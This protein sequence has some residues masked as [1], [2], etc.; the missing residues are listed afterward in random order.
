MAKMASSHDLLSKAFHAIN[1][2]KMDVE[3]HL[4]FGTKKQHPVYGVHLDATNIDLDKL[5]KLNPKVKVSIA[6]P[7]QRYS[8]LWLEYLGTL[9]NKVKR[10]ASV[11]ELRS[12]FDPYFPITVF[13]KNRP[14]GRNIKAFEKKALKE[15]FIV[16]E[17]RSRRSLSIGGMP[18]T[19]LR[20][21][22]IYW[23]NYDLVASVP[24]EHNTLPV[25]DAEK[26]AKAC[27]LLLG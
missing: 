3:K 15:G 9:P 17:I 25:F 7:G 26:G 22:S 6:Y 8:E 20:H 12:S 10:I 19:D 23:S 11:H 27:A 24:V 14:S 18:F 16:S 5:S 4:K 2:C 1:K 13:L 21:V